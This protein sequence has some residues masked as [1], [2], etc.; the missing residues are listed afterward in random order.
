MFNTVNL[1]SLSPHAIVL[2]LDET[3]VH[4]FLEIDKAV[5]MGVFA[6]PVLR[7]RAYYIEL[8]DVSSKKGEGEKSRLWGVFRPRVKEFL[9]FCFSYF[10]V[11]GIWSAG[12]KDYVT[13]VVELLFRDLQPPHFIYT[14]DNLH[15][16][17]DGS[18]YKPLDK[19]FKETT[20][21]S[22][23][24]AENVFA[25]D[26][27]LDVCGYNLHNALVVPAYCPETL[28]ELKAC[29]NTLQ[30]LISWFLLPKVRYCKDI[31]LL[32]KNIFQDVSEA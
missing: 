4:T 1:R 28:E 14:Y 7:T 30:T 11:V 24:K 25:L 2:D 15:H 27:R 18:Y 20:I 26:D 32:D 29:D 31:R 22:H 5:E 12:K 21:S 17:E 16:G 19:L 10:R 23:V 13:A 9:E 3:L 6:D 8:V